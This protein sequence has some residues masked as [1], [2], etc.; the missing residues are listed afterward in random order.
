MRTTAQ[1]IVSLYLTNP[2][3]HIVVKGTA[4]QRREICTLHEKDWGERTRGLAN[5]NSNGLLNECFE[6]IR[7]FQM[8]L[9]KGNIRKKGERG[10]Q[11]RSEAIRC[12]TAHGRPSSHLFGNSLNH[13]FSLA[14]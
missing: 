6:K 1:I 2:I 7:F 3:T 11:I 13:Q 12:G 5:H 4:Q 9:S 14:H 10:K 8:K